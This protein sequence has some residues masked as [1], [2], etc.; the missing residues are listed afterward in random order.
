MQIASLAEMPLLLVSVCCVAVVVAPDRRRPPMAVS[1]VVI[2][3]G[4]TRL[5]DSPAGAVIA[6]VAELR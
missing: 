5:W 4:D 1:P 6:I 2:V 3:V